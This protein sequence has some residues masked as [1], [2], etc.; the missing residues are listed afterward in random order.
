MSLPPKLANKYAGTIAAYI[1]GKDAIYIREI[2]ASLSFTGR[3]ES[4]RKV[5]RTVLRAKGFAPTTPRG[6]P[7]TSWV[8]Q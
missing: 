4:L 2:L 7:T 6:C 5:C 1:R 3:P 8:R